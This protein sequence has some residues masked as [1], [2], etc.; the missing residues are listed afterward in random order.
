MLQRDQIYCSSDLTLLIENLFNRWE[1]RRASSNISSQSFQQTALY[2]IT[3]QIISCSFSSWSNMTR[4]KYKSA[5]DVKNSTFSNDET[6]VA[7][8]NKEAE[9]NAVTRNDEFEQIGGEAP[10]KHI[11]GPFF[12]SVSNST[13]RRNSLHICRVVN[14]VDY[15]A[16]NFT[17]HQTRS[18]FHI[19]TLGEILQA[20]EQLS[21]AQFSRIFAQFTLSE[22]IDRVNRS[23]LNEAEWTYESSSSSEDFSK[24]KDSI[25]IFSSFDFCQLFD[26]RVRTRSSSIFSTATIQATSSTTAV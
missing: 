7:L 24:S 18:V 10:Q 1:L 5:L 26:L 22:V 25:F 12:S 20:Y 17:F 8:V 16:Q 23:E 4:R 13:S 6:S 21:H 3:D 11:E 2:S 14:S 19:N 15:K 9:R